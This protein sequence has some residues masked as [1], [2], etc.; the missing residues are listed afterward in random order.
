MG[1]APAQTRS[2]R[3]L[4][5]PIEPPLSEGHTSGSREGKMEHQFKLM[6]NVL[7]TPHDSPLPRGYIPGS[8]E[9]YTLFMD[10]TPMEINMLVEKKYPLIKELLEKMLNLQ[11]EAEEESTMAFEL[12]KFIK[13]MLEEYC[14]V[15]FG[16]FYS[17]LHDSIQSIWRFVRHPISKNRWTTRDARG[18]ICICGS[19]FSVYLKFMPSEDNEDKE[20]P[21]EDPKEDPTDYPA[22]RGDDDNDDDESSN[23]DEDD[24]DDV[25]EDEDE[26]EEH[27][28]PM[29]RNKLPTSF[30]PEAEIA[31][32]LA[33]P[34]PPPS[35]LSL[36]SSP[37][38]QIPSPPLPILSPV[39]VSPPP[40]PASPT[41]L[42]GFRAAMIQKRAKSPSTSH[43]LPLPPPIILS[44]TRASVA[45]MRAAAP[46][47]S[48]L[49][50]Q[51]KTT[52]SGTPLLLPI[53][54]T[55]SPPLI[56]PS[57]EH[58]VDMPEA[59]LP[60]RKRLCIAQGP[61][62]EVGES[63][64]SPRPT[65]GFRADY[66]FVATLDDEIRRHPERDVDYG[67]TD[68]WDEMLVGMP[69]A[70]A[71]DDT[72]L[73]R[74]MTNFRDRRSHAYTA[75]FME[76][77]AKI[78]REAWGRSMDASDTTRSEVRALKTT[79]L[80]QQKEIAPLRVV[81]RA[82][83][84]RLV[85]ILRLM[86]TL[87]TQK[88]ARKRTTRA[89]PAATTATTSVT[90]A[91]LKAMIDQGVTNALAVGDANRNTNGNDIHNSGTG[92]RRTE[93]VDR[94]C[95]YPDFIKCQPLNFKDL[96]KKMIDKY[97]PRGEI[98]KLEAEL[99]NLKVKESDKIKRY[100][101]GL[102]D[103]IHRSVVSSRPKTMQEAI[104]IATELMDKKIRNFAER[105]SENKR[106]QDDNQQQQ[107]KQN[108][109]QNTGR[110]Y[111]AGFGE[112][113]PY[114]GSKPLCSK[115]NYHHDGQCAPKCH[116]YNR[117]GHLARDC[118]STINA[119]AAN[120]QRGTRASQK[121]TCYECGAQ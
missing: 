22:D 47:T 50:S 20:D 103:M 88:M 32:L 98:K 119:N 21:E 45:M 74:R 52:P 11:L 48:I 67:I 59:C 104:E 73:G 65:G 2:E 96:K 53:Q 75:L 29:R 34:S 13:S 99:W 28:A 91:Q 24:D 10:G 101:R 85:E 30:W 94:E 61:R 71:T 90:N 114:K 44:H 18:S 79:V 25:E 116:K 105:Q 46:S 106:K 35:P 15:R 39:P 121:P 66:G 26:E 43:S 72:E 87:Q 4:E 62:Y 113:K 16:G 7:I 110:A 36:W 60:P 89:N 5:H 115:C 57:I 40:L 82:R 31:R 70:P 92:V 55:P 77:D 120:N 86:S 100:V 68:T 83:Q 19:R 17:H 64:S 109:R 33:I 108:K 107:Q 95:T 81:D 49:A 111:A 38:P 78:S 27:P 6:A 1:G 42:L 12:I 69:G 117:V 56:L 93:R 112:K 118:R 102:L 23:D 63:S 3:V 54:L 14:H 76:R 41:Y 37:L 80:A 8:D 84:A 58:R 9:V 51:S 97:C